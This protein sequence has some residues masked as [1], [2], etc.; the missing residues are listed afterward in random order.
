MSLSVLKRNNW[1][2]ESYENTGNAA[3]YFLTVWPVS[4]PRWTEEW[5]GGTLRVCRPEFGSE[6]LTIA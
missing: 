1:G 3:V 2:Q 6:D 5:E 4:V